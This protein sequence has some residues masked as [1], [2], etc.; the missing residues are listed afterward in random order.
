MKYFVVVLTV[1]VGVTWAN[2]AGAPLAACE[3]LTPQHG[4]VNPQTSPVPYAL[5]VSSKLRRGQTVNI[6]LRGNGNEDKIKGFLI[7]ARN[8]GQALGTF[9]PLDGNSQL[10]DCDGVKG[11]SWQ[12]LF[13]GGLLIILNNVVIL[14]SELHYS[15]TDHR[16]WWS[17]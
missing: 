8:G 2:S 16:R 15:Q 12:R 10:L 4:P 6:T 3:K 5:N 17:E 11:V 1:C 7:Q 14:L 13:D 9:S